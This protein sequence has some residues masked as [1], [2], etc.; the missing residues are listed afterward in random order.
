MAGV[1]WFFN[2]GL[3]KLS[4]PGKSQAGLEDG[5]RLEADRL[6]CGDLHGC[7]GLRVT[8]LTCGALFDFEGSKSD[9]LD[10][11]VLL[12]ASGDGGEDRFE[13]FVGGTLGGVFSE[14]ELDGFNQFRFVHGNDVSENGVG[15]WQEKIY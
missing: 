14:G 12:H 11:L 15:A 1:F 2:G 10:F 13:G 5:R 8:T 9:D 3:G 7:T 6:G 4:P